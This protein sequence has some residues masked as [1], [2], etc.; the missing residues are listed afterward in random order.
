MEP[1]RW[2][3]PDRAALQ[4]AGQSTPTR[5]ETGPTNSAELYVTTL[6][7]PNWL[8]LSVCLSIYGYGKDL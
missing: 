1:S 7:L 2:W 8:Y 5:T 6:G 3:I 4:P